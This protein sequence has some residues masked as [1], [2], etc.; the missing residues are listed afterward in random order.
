[1]IDLNKDFEELLKKHNIKDAFLVTRII[2]E[3][4]NNIK[5]LVEKEEGA[6]EFMD[7]LKRLI[8]IVNFDTV[9]INVVCDILEENIKK[10]KILESESNM[11][12]KDKKNLKKLRNDKNIA[13][14]NRDYEKAADLRDQE[15]KILGIVEEQKEE[16]VENINDIS[17]T[18]KNYLSDIEKAQLLG[19]RLNNCY[20]LSIST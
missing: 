4:S 19:I 20:H 5:L 18:I 14:K 16:F 1:M 10:R 2:K 7:Q 11:L 13:V 15:L 3:D 17:K 8:S 6:R 9:S 12:T